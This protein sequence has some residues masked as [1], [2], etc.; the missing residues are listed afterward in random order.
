[1]A[2]LGGSGPTGAAQLKRYLWVVRILTSTVYPSDKGAGLV[3]S[4]TQ[5]GDILRQAY[6][7]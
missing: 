1:M 2:G 7:P 4:V 5:E 3:F 6:I